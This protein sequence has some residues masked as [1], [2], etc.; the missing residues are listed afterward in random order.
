M[1]KR[2]R[3]AALLLAVLAALIFVVHRVW[4]Y[5]PHAFSLRLDPESAFQDAVSSNALLIRNATLVDVVEGTTVRNAHVH[6]RGDTI[7]EV[8]LG[9][10]PE[11]D[12]N[13]KVYDAG[14]KYVMPGLIDVHVHLMMHPQPMH[15]K[16]GPKDALASELALEQFVRYGVT[17][18]LVLGG[19]G[20][21]DEQ[22]AELKRRERANEIIAPLIYATG[23]LITAPGSHPI[24][25]IMRLPADTDP[26]YLHHAGVTVIGPNN[27]PSSIIAKKKR[28]GLDGV[29]LMIEAGPPPW[30]PNPRMSRETASRIA[31]AA[32]RHDLPVYAH[33]LSYSDFSDAIDVGVDGTMHSVTDTLIDDD[34]L[35]ERMKKDGIFYVPTFSQF[36]GFQSLDKPERMRDSYLQAG[37]S[38]RTLRGLQHPLFRFFLGRTFRNQNVSG[39]LDTAMR[40]LRR[41]HR[42]GVRIVLG[43]DSGTPFNFQGYSAHVEM[44]LMALAGLDNVDVIRAATVN[45]AAF[46]QMTDKLGTIERGKVAN[47]LVL[48][49]NPLA[50]IRH[51]RTIEEVILKGRIINP[52]EN[53]TTGTNK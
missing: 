21:N 38:Q 5:N 39:W 37:I 13:V 28:L 4:F 12:A 16:L 19:V 3:I 44:E 15:G 22:A 53:P 32:H 52:P 47:L 17:T 6:I 25:T 49:K 45:G 34:A 51:T 30:Y 27:D 2:F 8:V 46:L 18:V 48:A 11:I 14:N 23:D 41:L 36:Y 35:I 26:V 33:A 29:K 43:T 7:A 24:T 50:D 1:K 20:A 40:N 9:E 10:A 31:K 42:E